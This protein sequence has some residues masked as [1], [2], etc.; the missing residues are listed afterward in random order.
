M[1]DEIRALLLHSYEV[2]GTALRRALEDQFI[3]TEMAQSISEANDRISCS[4]PP[5][6]V[7]T[8][9]DLFDGTWSDVVD[10]ADRA[11]RQVRVIVVSPVADIPL[12]M[13]V[14]ERKAYDFITHS[15]T[16]PELTHILRC[17]VDD[18]V[19]QRKVPPRLPVGSTID[20]VSEG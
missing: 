17:A 18:I 14:M 5:H 1:A 20:R 19:R 12:Y 4:D 11:S 10:L 13:D 7:F 2:P 8:G 9:T 3:A 16:A 6:L 15:F